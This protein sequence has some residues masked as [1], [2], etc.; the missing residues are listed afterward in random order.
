MQRVPASDYSTEGSIEDKTRREI[1]LKLIYV[2]FGLAGF[3]ILTGA[4]LVLIDKFTPENMINLVLV[5]SALFSGLLGSAV[6][7]YYSAK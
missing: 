7:F 5:V 3:A 6:T 4:A 2:S 1:A